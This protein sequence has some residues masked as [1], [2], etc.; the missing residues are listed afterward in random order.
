MLHCGDHALGS[1]VS[2]VFVV[3]EKGMDNARHP[4]AHGDKKLIR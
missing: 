1:F 2:E 3:H 4:E